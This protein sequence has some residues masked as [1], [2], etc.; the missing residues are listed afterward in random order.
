M[1]IYVWGCCCCCCEC[2]VVVVV[3]VGRGRGRRRFRK[4]FYKCNS[5]SLCEVGLI[6][7]RRQELFDFTK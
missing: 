7:G 3:V 1:N 2:F 4:L 6:G 5:D